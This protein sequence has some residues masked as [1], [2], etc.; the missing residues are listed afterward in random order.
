MNDLELSEGLKNEVATL[1][2]MTKTVAVRNPDERALVYQAVQSVKIKK[3]AI[4]DFFAPSKTAAA[5]AHKAICANEKSFTDRLDAFELAG[6]RAIVSYD[7]AEN[8]KRLAEQR[9]LQAIADEQARKERERAEAEARRQREIEEANRRKAEEARRQAEAA[10]DAERERL[11]KEAEAA[12]RKAAAAQVKAET[13]TENAAAV[14]APVVQVAPVAEKQKGEST[15]TIWRA[16]IIKISDIPAQYYLSNGKVTNAIQSAI[17][18][19]A[20]ATKGAVQLP[21][22]EFYEEKSLAVR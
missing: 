10:S 2:E 18:D 1:E 13:Q 4:V 3:K 7:E 20:K 19:F 5:A 11:L 9:R 22:V 17:D 15:R 6:K 8:Q 21:G 14:I 16:R 12:E